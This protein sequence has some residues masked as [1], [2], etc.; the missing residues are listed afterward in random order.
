[1]WEELDAPDLEGGARDIVHR[2]HDEIHE[3]TVEDPGIAI[4]VNTREEYGREVET[5]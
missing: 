2:H 3:V 4:D 5:A 1:M